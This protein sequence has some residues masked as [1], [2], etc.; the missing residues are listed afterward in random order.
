MHPSLPDTEKVASTMPSWGRKKNVMPRLACA[1]VSDCGSVGLSSDV[2]RAV[3]V[4]M[5]AAWLTWIVDVTASPEL[6]RSGVLKYSYPGIVSCSTYS[7]FAPVSKS[8]T[9]IATSAADGSTIGAAISSHAYDR[10][11]SSARS[12]EHANGEYTSAP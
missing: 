9:V 7:P 6:A 1:A 8:Y 4:K 11:S 3:D 10:R 2:P 12:A 5:C